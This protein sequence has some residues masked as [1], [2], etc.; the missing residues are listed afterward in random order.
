M[1][2]PSAKPG[3]I[4]TKTHVNKDANAEIK[5]MP[6]F[7]LDSEDGLWR[8]VYGK[9]NPEC[10]YMEPIMESEWSTRATAIDWIMRCLYEQRCNLEVTIGKRVKNA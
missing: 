6:G 4:P 5:K 9:C 10:D 8:G 1:P 3:T 2:K 7:W